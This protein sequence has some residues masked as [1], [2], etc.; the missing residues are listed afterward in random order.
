MTTKAEDM[1]A[2]LQ[3]HKRKLA[4]MLDS[5]EPLEEG[6]DLGRYRYEASMAI[7]AKRIADTLDNILVELNWQNRD[8]A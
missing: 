2:E 5:I 1:E 6:I 7:S 3:E 8:K 4:L